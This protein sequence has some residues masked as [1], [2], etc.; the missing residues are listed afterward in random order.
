ML[1]ADSLGES[2]QIAAQR[3]DCVTG[4]L[5]LL[6]VMFIGLQELCVLL[7]DLLRGLARRSK[8]QRLKVVVQ[9]LPGRW[10]HLTINDTRIQVP[11]ERA[12]RCSCRRQGRRLG[13][14]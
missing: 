13:H 5:L 8:Q 6:D 14:C 7:L 1:G 4:D 12:R 2:S 11:H 3:G 10:G 9:V